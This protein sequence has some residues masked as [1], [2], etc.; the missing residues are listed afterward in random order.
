M[1]PNLYPALGKTREENKKF[2]FRRL[3]LSNIELEIKT[4]DLNFRKIDCKK[5]TNFRVIDLAMDK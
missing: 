3:K 1:S 2:H 4:N 5:N